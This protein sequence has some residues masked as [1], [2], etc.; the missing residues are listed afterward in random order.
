MNE[1]KPLN[2]IPSIKDCEICGEEFVIHSNN[3]RFCSQECYNKHKKEYMINWRKSDSIILDRDRIYKCRAWLYIQSILLE[4]S[5]IKIA[6]EAITSPR[7]IG[8]WRR[9][10]NII[11]EI[12]DLDKPYR[13][14]GWLYIQY[15]L[16]GKTIKQI[17]IETATTY[18]RIRH[19]KKIFK[20][21]G[22]DPYQ[23]RRTGKDHHS[24]SGGIT[25][26]GSGYKQIRKPNHSRASQSGYVFEQILV[27]EN[28]LKR[29][30]WKWEVIHHIN[31][32]KD[33]NKIDNLY[34]CE[35]SSQHH[36]IHRQLGRIAIK[37]FKSQKFGKI[38]FDKDK[39]KYYLEFEK[40]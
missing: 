21:K 15:W 14:R 5:D 6:K 4:K 37:L 22:R 23:N 25:Y 34:L 12:K 26:H 35:N 19:Y 8:N 24:W 13:C 9:K 40:K 27:M 20:M 11:P 31:E 17:S 32:V 28:H 39:G 10:F 3:Q 30:L 16:L 29:K 2:Y 38:K 1:L 33:D 7:T 36:K 18:D